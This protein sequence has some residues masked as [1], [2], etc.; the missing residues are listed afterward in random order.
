MKS[1]GGKVSFTKNISP[2]QMTEMLCSSTLVISRLIL[3]VWS[4]MTFDLQ[5]K[6]VTTNNDVHSR[7]MRHV[8]ISKSKSKNEPLSP[9]R[10][11]AGMQSITLGISEV[12]RAVVMGSGLASLCRLSSSNYPHLDLFYIFFMLNSQSPGK[13]RNGVRD[14]F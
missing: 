13:N 8:D 3:I 1:D 12:G 11:G 7:E 2:A 6:S 10:T 14:I 9:T 4:W 5:N